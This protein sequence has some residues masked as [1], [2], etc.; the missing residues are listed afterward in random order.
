[1][2]KICFVTGSRAEYGLLR[3]LIIKVK[4]DKKIKLQLVVTCMHLM[5]KFGL[6][7]KEILKDGLKINFK[8]KMPISTSNPE[9][10]T[11]ATGL[12]MIGFAKVFK[13]MKPDLLVVLGDRFEILSAAFAA[14][15]Q[16]IPIA[17]IGGGESTV[18]AIDESIRHSVTKMSTI[19]FVSTNDYKKRV[20]QL[21]E[22]PSNIFVVGS[23]GV[24][25]IKKIKLYS[26][27][28]IEEMMKF[29]LEKNNILFTYHSA[30]LNN[31]NE[32]KNI[33]IILK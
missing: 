30:T 20:I 26:R 6:T 2:K 25:R 16:K 5:P 15:S 11:K 17:H 9:N 14:H 13:K 3:D 19:H 23:L 12:G 10:I 7:Y 28:K 32:K 33:E 8:V 29:K 21:G 1:M 4:N 31:Y 27:K 22:K 24:D 18:A